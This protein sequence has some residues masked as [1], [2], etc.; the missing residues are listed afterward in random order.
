MKRT[1]ALVD[2]LISDIENKTVFAFRLINIIPLPK[3]A[4][5]PPQNLRYPGW[6]SARFPLGKRVDPQV[7]PLAESYGWKQWRG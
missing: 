6:D 5:R 4:G 3:I 1:D 2:L 7:D